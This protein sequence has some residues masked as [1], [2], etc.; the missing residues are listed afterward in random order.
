MLLTGNCG[1]WGYKVW[2]TGGRE[3]LGEDLLLLTSLPRACCRLWASLGGGAASGW[4]LVIFMDQTLGE[5]SGQLALGVA[6]FRL[7]GCTLE[8]IYSPKALD[9]SEGV[10]LVTLKSPWGLA[11]LEN[12]FDWLLELDVQR[13]RH[14]FIAVILYDTVTIH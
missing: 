4:T 1:S 7:S 11:I 3:R 5:H 10:T 14:Y 12:I 6:F 8:T 13:N 9:T 2:G